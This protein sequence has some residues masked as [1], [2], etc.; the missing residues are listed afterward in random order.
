MGYRSE[1]AI[2]CEELA[3]EKFREV[4]TNAQFVPDKVYKDGEYFILYWV[5]WCDMFDEVSSIEHA[6]F[7]LDQIEDPNGY[8]Y[9]YIRIG[10]CY[11]DVET[12]TNNYDI[13]LQIICKIDIPDNV[14]QISVDESKK[15]ETPL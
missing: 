14:E 1:V 2:K 11:D 15:V 12:K 5:K 4:Y 10:E 8:G 13:T 9:I 3:F 7:E 6:M